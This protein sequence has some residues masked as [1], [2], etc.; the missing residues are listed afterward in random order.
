[1]TQMNKH[2][3]FIEEFNQENGIQSGS[4]GLLVPWTGHLHNNKVG[5]S[6]FVGNESH[7]LQPLFIVVDHGSVLTFLESLVVQF[8]TVS[9]IRGTLCHMNDSVKIL[10]SKAWRFV[11]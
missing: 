4:N 2:I 8:Q 5:F 10:G 6:S 7:K 1:M 11:S 3:N 9:I